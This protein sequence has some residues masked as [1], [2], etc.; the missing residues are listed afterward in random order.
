MKMRKQHFAQAVAPCERQKIVAART[1][2]YDK[3]MYQVGTQT[4]RLLSQVWV[5]VFSS[6]DPRGSVLLGRL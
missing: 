3:E 6:A 2:N 4:E 5:H 1:D